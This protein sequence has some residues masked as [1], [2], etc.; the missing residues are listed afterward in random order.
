MEPPYWLDAALAEYAKIK[1]DRGDSG[2]CHDIA[3]A[4]IRDLAEGNLADG[5]MWCS[6]NVDNGIPH[7]WVEYRKVRIDMD[8]K[9]GLRFCPNDQS[10]FTIDG[11]VIRKNSTQ[12]LEWVRTWNAQK[13]LK[14]LTD[15]A[16][17]ITEEARHRIKQC[18]ELATLE[19]WR[20]NASTT[21]SVERL[22]TGI[23]KPPQP[24]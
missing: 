4:I 16:I 23:V 20:A 13:I 8:E 1:N 14:L 5:W 17:P 22:I 3:I 21:E 7:S 2:I 18:K 15:H 19:R 11:A 24:D 10:A 6:G 12:T 9:G